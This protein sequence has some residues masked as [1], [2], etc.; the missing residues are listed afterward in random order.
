MELLWND[1]SISL[2]KRNANSEI[3]WKKPISKNIKIKNIGKECVTVSK[4]SI[5]KKNL[6]TGSV[7]H[8]GL[9]H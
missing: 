6:F 8:K 7:F 2:L 1:A 5:A 4:G 3:I 9:R